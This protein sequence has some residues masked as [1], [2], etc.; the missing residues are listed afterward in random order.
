MCG[1]DAWEDKSAV[2]KGKSLQQ[3]GTVYIQ[4]ADG[5]RWRTA[6]PEI[7]WGDVGTEVSW[8]EEVF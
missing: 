7:G 1:E 6:V 8:D 2:R 4:A 3:S 5:P